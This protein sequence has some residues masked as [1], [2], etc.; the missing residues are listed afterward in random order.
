MAQ[1]A[2][3]AAASATSEAPTKSPT[4]RVR[5]KHGRL[6]VHRSPPKFNSNGQIVEESSE[7]RYAEEGE[8]VEVSRAWAEKLCSRQFD[9]YPSTTV[10]GAP[11]VAPGVIKDSPIEILG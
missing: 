2:Q 5:I 1:P 8:V 11:G 3:S 4:V 7:D 9:G 10:N 6:L